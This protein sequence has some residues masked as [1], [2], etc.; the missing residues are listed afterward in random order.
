MENTGIYGSW[1]DTHKC[2]PLFKLRGYLWDDLR[3]RSVFVSYILEIFL[4]I[5]AIAPRIWQ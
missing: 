3:N 1:A 4:I 5:A 2:I